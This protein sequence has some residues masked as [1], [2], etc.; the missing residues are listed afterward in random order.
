MSSSFSCHYVNVRIV[1]ERAR[2]VDWIILN[3]TVLYHEACRVMTD[4]SP[5]ESIMLFRLLV[6]L[7]YHIN[8][9]NFNQLG[10]DRTLQV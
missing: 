4:S 10:I 2:G 5:D 6:A 3:I 1:P 7:C 9:L 8:Y